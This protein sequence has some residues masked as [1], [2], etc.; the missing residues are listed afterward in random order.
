MTVPKQLQL[1]SAVLE[2]VFCYREVAV[3]FAGGV[4]VFTGANG[5]GKSSL[6]EAVFFGLF[7]S[8]TKAITGRDMGQVLRDGARKGSLLVS[9]TLGADEY[10]VYLTLKR[11]GERVLAEGSDCL[12]SQNGIA[13]ATGVKQIAEQMEALLNMSGEDFAHCLYVRQGEVDQLIRATQEE[14]QSI[15]DR[16]LRLTKIDEY[17]QRLDKESRRALRRRQDELQGA[18]KKSETE[19]KELTT[20]DLPAQLARLER[21]LA[22]L[23][24]QRNEM[25]NL[26]MQALE[27]RRTLQETQNRFEQTAQKMRA[28]QEEY[29]QLKAQYDQSEEQLQKLKE[30]IRGLKAE[31]G[32]LENQQ[33]QLQRQE[34]WQ[35]LRVSSEVPLQDRVAELEQDVDK[36]TSDLQE[37]S[38]LRSRLQGERRE[39][40]R[41][42][43]RLEG[44]VGRKTEE[45]QRVNETLERL[46]TNLNRNLEKLGIR[47]EALETL[48]LKALIA[49]QKVL[50]EREQ[51][52]FDNL[53]A[54]NL[55]LKN[56]H[57]AL[58]EQ[59]QE[60]E[61]LVS[62]GRCPTCKQPVTAATLADYADPLNEKL[63]ECMRKLEAIEPQLEACTQ[64]TEQANKGLSLLQ[65]EVQ[66]SYRS[67][68]AAKDK[69]S[70]LA[71]ELQESKRF[72]TVE[73]TALEA[74]K[75]QERALA[76]ENTQ[77]MLR[78]ERVK[79]D[80]KRLKEAQEIAEKLQHQAER[81]AQRTAQQ[82]AVVQLRDRQKEELINLTHSF[83]ELR[84]QLGEQDI[85]QLEVAINQRGQRLLELETKLKVIDDK[86]SAL[87]ELKGK[88][89]A[90]WERL[91]KL[92]L[93][94]QQQKERLAR[95]GS[96]ETEVQRLGDLYEQI[97]LNLRQRNLAALNKVF[98]D[99]FTLMD[100]SPAYDRIE[101][102]KEFD[103]E[104]VRTDE[105]RMSPAILSGGERALINLALRAAIHA[106]ISDA[107]G[108]LL[109]L[110]FDE[111]TVFLDQNHVRQ[112]E[113]LFKAL[114]T[115]AGQV[116][117]VSHEA[118]LVE[119][120]DHEYR[121]SKDAD[122]LGCVE[123][124]R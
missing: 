52:Q 113:H 68:Q 29:G 116:I 104:V 4:S 94:I 86:R 47:C 88:L 83:E 77:L 49:Q 2:N 58:R 95:L 51:A 90:D 57:K 43:G 35:A 65:E 91:E 10:T 71:Q 8:S 120:A 3:D 107:G 103:I 30:E 42:L 11:S 60:V 26:H 74:L 15:I 76:E 23:D 36:A 114:G 16:L 72:H 34:W 46:G 22:Q 89:K 12:L 78:Q 121:V 48:D 84:G 115:R 56:Q 33:R 27:E 13:K 102:N 41:T 81:V 105:Q 82:S 25:S 44:E 79:T 61:E 109:P 63:A 28:L 73:S 62:A 32:E 17:K 21:E 19:H 111:P 112:L 66:T 59:A 87:G 108:V 85:Q 24:G 9:F 40:E 7:G 50:C 45:A 93:E 37:K 70:Q 64:R 80:L 110:L 106:V 119:S 92:G 123:K 124:V 18:L 100:P 99:F 96:L 20:A 98:N 101:L 122:N 39:K 6:L 5:S 54:G 118:S 31:H 67:W 55:E 1:K 69:H 117:V 97:R 53:R 75:Q 38:P 14:R